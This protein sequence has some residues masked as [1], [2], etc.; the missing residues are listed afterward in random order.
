[1]KKRVRIL[2]ALLSGIMLLGTATVSG[3]EDAEIYDSYNYEEVG[4]VDDS[5]QSVKY[6]D[7]LPLEEYLEL[8]PEAAEGEL[9]SF[10]LG[11][12]IAQNPVSVYC[13]PNGQT[14]SDFVAIHDVSEYTINDVTLEEYIS[15]YGA[16]T[17]AVTNGWYQNSSGKWQYY[18][19]GVAVAGEWRYIDGVW[20][21]F[22]PD[23]YMVSGAWRQINGVWYYLKTGGA[24]AKGWLEIGSYWYYF[25]SDGAM[26]TGFV[27]IGGSEYYFR[28][29][30]TSASNYGSMYQGL[31][32]SV[33]NP[34]CYYGHPNNADAG[35]KFKAG[36][37]ELTNGWYYAKSETG[38][39][40][41]GL[42]VISRDADGRRE[43]N[44]Y[45]FNTTNKKMVTG[46]FTLS[47]R[48]YYA[49]ENVSSSR[50][51]A[52][53]EAYYNVTTSD[54]GENNYNCVYTQIDYLKNLNY[55]TSIQHYISPA[56]Y[57]NE[58]PA[59]KVV[60]V[61]GHGNTNQINFSGG[62][63]KGSLGHLYAFKSQIP[64]DEWLNKQP[65]AISSYSSGEL[66]FVDL[67]IYTACNSAE[68]G[69]NSIAGQTKLKGAD[70]VIGYQQSVTNGEWFAEYFLYY[71]Q[72]YPDTDLNTWVGLAAIKFNLEWPDMKDN[73]TSP[74]N[75]V[76]NLTV[77]N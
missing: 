19:N 13:Q 64:D 55:Y 4:A 25:E 28:D 18:E 32:P 53:W 37:L 3:A 68:G 67:V 42:E 30:N 21:Y 2:A 77:F 63:G 39:L 56:Q 12:Y 40:A 71:M 14:L 5:P 8:Y 44:R 15:L 38:K 73:A 7:D 47:G 9:G 31:Y 33:S 58:L 54:L 65:S 22:D 59:Q 29:T 46:N 34:T 1:M 74:S 41:S 43:K 16:S 60:I 70:T 72:E 66:S 49:D 11:D 24:M 26:V 36:W 51:G 20:Y 10:G 69:N 62:P 75:R 35:A 27:T 76:D 23:S 50:Y 6:I 48:E 45:Y 61:H 17:M 52:V 57:Y